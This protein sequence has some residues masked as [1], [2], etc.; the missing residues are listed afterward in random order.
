MKPTLSIFYQYDPWNSSIGGIQTIINNFIKY[1]PEDFE[2]K[3]VG[4]DA[5]GNREIGSWSRENFLGRDIG[6]LPIIATGN[7]DRRK[8]V[9]T[10][11]SYTAALI[12]YGSKIKSDFFHF[13][14][15]EPSFSMWRKAGEKTLFIHND[16]HQQLF[17][18]DQADSIMWRKFPSIY[19]GLEGNLIKKIDR[20]LC[21]NSKSVDFYK[22]RYP[23][24]ADRVEFVTNS[25]DT[26]T[27][28]FSNI[29]HKNIERT[30]LAQKI[31]IDENA[32]FIFFA[33]RLHPQKDPLL[34]IQAMALVDFP[35]AHLLIAGTG[36]LEEKVREEVNNLGLGSRVTFLGKLNTAEMASVHRAASTFVLTSVY[37]G[38]PLVALESLSCGTPVVTTNCGETPRFLTT[39]TGVIC[40]DRSPESVAE[41]IQYVV[42]HNSDFP[43]EACANS[44]TPYSA[45]TII[46]I[47][48][49]D[50]RQRW[51]DQ[52]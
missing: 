11:L 30:K 19:L 16:V 51:K 50:M 7:D 26:E 1:S 49:K 6:F 31:G 34:L 20:I 9:P 47:I 29:E 4:S 45:K 43:S 13:H 2:V 25:V 33:G 24:L 23:K 37:E 42:T 12:R 15:I 35:L 14:R 8:L 5:T 27:F 52:R 36:E 18:N 41:S 17:G 44:A 22:S 10:T 32:R 46:D 28:Y 40:K 21:C 48:Y 39:N 38:L 3:I